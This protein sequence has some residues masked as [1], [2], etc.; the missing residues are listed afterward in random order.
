MV[1]CFTK[2]S[3]IK[4][5]FPT[6]LEIYAYIHTINISY[7]TSLDAQF[8]PQSK[9]YYVPFKFYASSICYC[10]TRGYE[11]N[12]HRLN[13]SFN[14]AAFISILPYIL[15]M[16]LKADAQAAFSWRYRHE[17]TISCSL[18]LAGGTNPAQ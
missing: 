4:T 7:L 5:N 16:K 10:I 1:R 11:H 18:L 9:N 6:L 2:L 14:P 17:G 15:T 13:Q 3:R 12:V 8:Y